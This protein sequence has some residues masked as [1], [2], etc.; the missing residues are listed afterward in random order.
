MLDFLACHSIEKLVIDAEAI[1][2]AQ[3]LLSGIEVRT[4]KLAVDMFSQAGAHGDFLKLK[5]TRTLFRKEQHFPSSI[6]DRS[7]GNMADILDRARLRVNELVES[8]RRPVITP[9]VEDALRAI[10]LRESRSLGLD[11]LPGIEVPAQVTSK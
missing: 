5:E 10:A 1:A 3:R 7:G 4:E 11:H 8:Y 6:I 9:E 2:S